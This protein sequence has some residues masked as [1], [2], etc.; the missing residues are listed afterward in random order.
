MASDS[1]S[2]LNDLIATCGDCVEGFRKAAK[3]A[4]SDTLR[5]VFTDCARQHAVFADELAARVREMGAEPAAM[6]HYGVVLDPGWLDLET[7]IRPEVDASFLA[8]CQRGEESAI[9]HYQTALRGPLPPD[10]H[11]LVAHQ[12]QAMQATIERLR[13]LEQVRRAG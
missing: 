2:V 12:L 13:G 11:S 3:G 7:R 8:E 9:K 1:V 4:H 6:P 5:D 10:L